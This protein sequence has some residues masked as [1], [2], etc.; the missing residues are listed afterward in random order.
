M[1]RR[2]VESVSLVVRDD[3]GG[4]QWMLL[5]HRSGNR[6]VSI[7]NRARR[8]CRPRAHLLL[9]LEARDVRYVKLR[10]GREY[11][12]L[13]RITKASPENNMMSDRL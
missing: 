13:R 5:H 9:E 6:L 7:T 10:G 4:S 8:C 1:V 11:L 2:Y 12:M 3:P